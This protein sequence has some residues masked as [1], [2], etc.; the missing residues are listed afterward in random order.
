M[1]KLQYWELSQLNA[2]IEQKQECFEQASE[3]GVAEA[4]TDEEIQ[5][6]RSIIRRRFELM[7]QQS[8][9]RGWQRHCLQEL[10]AYYEW[11]FAFEE[12][13]REEQENSFFAYEL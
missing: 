8:T 10:T 4:V 3:L 6:F 9:G 5:M 12:E 1:E 7:C 2:L 11:I 13:R